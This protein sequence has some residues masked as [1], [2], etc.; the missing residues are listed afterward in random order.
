[1][2]EPHAPQDSVKSST[3]TDREWERAR[4]AVERKHKLRGDIFAYVV[5]NLALVVA[6]AATGFGSFWPGWVMGIWG[7]FL[8]LDMWTVFYRRPVTDDDIRRELHSR[9][10]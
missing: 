5:I 3:G 8:V 1:M 7:T 6:W 2:V 4:S 10:S 9:Q